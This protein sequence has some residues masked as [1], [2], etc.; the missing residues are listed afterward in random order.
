MIILEEY[1]KEKEGIY[2]ES[3][4]VDNGSTGTNF[5]RQ[6]WNEMLEDLKNK[7]ITCIVVKDFSRIGRNYI[8]V[9]D[10]LEKVFPFLGV[11]V[12]SVNDNYDS[13]LENYNESMIKNSL[14]NVM[15]EYYARDISK[16]VSKAKIVLQKDGKF[17]S[18]IIP[19]GY[20]RNP[21]DKHKLVIDKE[22]ADVVKKIYQWRVLGKGCILIANLLNE[23]L[24]PSPGHYKYMNGDKRFERSN[25]V[26]WKSKHV[27]AILSNPLY[28]GHMTQGK[29]HSSYFS[30][31]PMEF[32]PQEEWIIVENTHEALVSQQ[33]FDVV[34][35]MAKESKYDLIEKQARNKNLPR[36]E[37]PFPK[38][39]YCGQCGKLMT[40]RSRAED[41][42]FMYQYFCNAPHEKFGRNC[43]DTYIKEIVLQNV[44]EDTLQKHIELLKDMHK[45]IVQVKNSSTY[46]LEM[47][48]KE[49]KLN[50]VS[51]NIEFFC[52]R[53]N[54][55]YADMKDGLL[56]KEDYLFA[57]SKYTE[58]IEQ[59]KTQYDQIKSEG[60]L[61]CIQNSSVTDCL[62]EA[63]GCTEITPDIV[64]LLVKKIVVHSRNRVEVIFNFTNEIEK[65][66]HILSERGEKLA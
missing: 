17:I 43:K 22:S 33:E 24:L 52:K 20:Q 46:L 53:K 54:A 66:Y 32:L 57:K 62:Q 11:R 21:M 59:L 34:Q 64:Q 6:A 60:E 15:N 3:R 16:K 38:L 45:K 28:L 8:E 63:A 58:E 1:V 19:Y 26:K 13:F 37:M 2:L 25:Q 12:I 51:E 36:K 47:K 48:F 9:G 39:V 5:D 50:A 14:L 10:Y 61:N 49:Q 41:G 31:K 23:L 44:V 40:R 56:T 65:I 27:V 42:K 55:L 30:D 29:T 4:Y 7:K 18:P 35:E